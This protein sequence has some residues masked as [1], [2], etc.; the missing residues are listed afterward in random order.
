MVLNDKQ[1]NL[2]LSYF[3]MDDDDK[4]NYLKIRTRLEWTMKDSDECPHDL[5]VGSVMFHSFF[6]TFYNKLKGLA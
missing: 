3:Y 2:V 6:S 5:Y 4:Y 1:K